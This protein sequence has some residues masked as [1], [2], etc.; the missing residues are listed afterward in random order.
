M[1]GQR[2]DSDAGE[3]DRAPR[4]LALRRAEVRLAPV[5]TTSWR[6]IRMDGRVDGGISPDRSTV[7]PVASLIRGPAAAPSGTSARN[8]GGRATS[9]ASTCAVSNGTT[10]SWW[11]SGSFDPSHG[12]EAM[13]RSRIAALK[14]AATTPW[15]TA[16]VAG[17]SVTDSALTHAWISLGRIER[18]GRDPNAG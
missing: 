7:R 10:G 2:L 18:S 16:T 11:S 1:C 9:N 3:R 14:T 15:A 12:D 5:R 4:R 17:A 13:S 8:R 6:S